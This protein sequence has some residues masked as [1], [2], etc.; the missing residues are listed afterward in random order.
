MLTQQDYKNIASDWDQD[1]IL[2][3]CKPGDSS[4]PCTD[5]CYETWETELKKVIPAYNATVELT[6]QLQNKFDFI[7]SRRDRYKTWVDEFDKAETLARDICSQL[8]LIAVQSDK[9]WYN[10]CEAEKAI[11]I[12]F[13]M[14]RDIYM[15]IDELKTMFDTLQNCI[16]RNND[17]AL[18]KGQ[19]ILKYIDDYK[20]KLDATVKTRDDVIKNI[21]TAIK[22]ATLIRNGI[23]T[24]DCEEDTEHHYKPCDPDNDP[25]GCVDD[26]VYYGLKAVICEWYNEFACDTECS[27]SEEST[28]QSVNKHHSGPSPHHDDNPNCELKP[29]FNFPI[30][31]NKFKSDV[32]KW[33]DEDNATLA[34]LLVD[35][36][37]AKEK[38]QSLLACKNSLDQAIKAVDPVTRCK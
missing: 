14:I 34:T 22:V 2:E 30:C 33:V 6:T 12:L 17:P 28:S 11:E 36:N 38:Q 24:R 23:S 1:T 27:D 19:G 15:Q 7:T 4:Q 5:C 25:C 10:A 26:A 8:R 13:C 20:A 21:V 35:L 37:N 31:N 3:C 32:Q 29:D 18:A 16:T 9:I